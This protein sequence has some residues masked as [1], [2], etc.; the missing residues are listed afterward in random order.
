MA[1]F[2]LFIAISGLVLAIWRQYQ[3]DNNQS[4][5]MNKEWK[6]LKETQIKDECI[7]S[8]EEAL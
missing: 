3:Y 5:I 4:I 6:S 8:K 7:P 2:I 1:A